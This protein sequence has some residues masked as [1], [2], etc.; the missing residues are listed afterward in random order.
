MNCE[1]VSLKVSPASLVAVKSV[2]PVNRWGRFH[3]H[4]ASP[5]ELPVHHRLLFASTVRHFKSIAGPLYSLSTVNNE[6]D[7]LFTLLSDG[8][9]QEEG[10]YVSNTCCVRFCPTSVYYLVLNCFY[11]GFIY[12]LQINIISYHWSRDGAWWFTRQ[13]SCHAVC[14]I[15][16]NVTRTNAHK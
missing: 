1:P 14:A 8:A 15:S 16:I 4:Y 5:A 7:L 12:D 3:R 10:A 2:V 13:K 9:E 6:N 11:S